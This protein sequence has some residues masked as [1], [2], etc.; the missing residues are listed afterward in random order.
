MAPKKGMWEILSVSCLLSVVLLCYGSNSEDY[1]A[2]V[3]VGDWVKYEDITISGVLPSPE[4]NRIWM[5]IEVQSIEITN[6]TILLS[7]CV[8]IGG[9]EGEVGSTLSGNIATGSGD[10][11]GFIIPSNLARGDTIPLST[12]G[13][14]AP[15]VDNVV[16][17]SYAGSNRKTVFCDFSADDPYSG[18]V[19]MYWDQKT[20][21]LLEL[22]V[23]MD[24]PTDFE[25]IVRATETSIWTGSS[26]E[27]FDHSPLT[28][29]AIAVVS[30]VTI[31]I[32]AVIYREITH[33]SKA[34]HVRSGRREK[35]V[36]H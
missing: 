14:E 31:G 21:V 34:H 35:R 24:L 3:N 29:Q 10:L 20:G 22:N 11:E 23:D 4:L 33:R 1:E 36:K 30:I 26:I 5:K 18:Q 28:F 8:N 32:L 15:V 2:G 6:V 27:P 12:Y 9:W 16:T 25:M 17:R 7:S 19:G 13:S